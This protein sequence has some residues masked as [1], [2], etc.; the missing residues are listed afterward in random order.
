MSNKG[1][2]IENASANSTISKKSNKKRRLIKWV[3]IIAVLLI[4]IV[5]GTWVAL[6]IT[7][8]S[9]FKDVDQAVADVNPRKFG[10]VLQDSSYGGSGTDEPPDRF[11]EILV[12]KPER[13]AGTMVYQQLQKAGFV[14]NQIGNYSWQ[15]TK[16]GKT[17][18]I[19]EFT[20]KSGVY[21]TPAGKTKLFL[22][23]LQIN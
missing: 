6:K 4:W 3:I 12:D 11:F 22:E 19:Q 17:V 7:H 10:N 15:R 9:A 16:N 1:I 14:D 2:V 5:I 20:Y 13:E 18:D 23:F 21:G 8:K